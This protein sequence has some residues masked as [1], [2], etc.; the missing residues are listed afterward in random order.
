MTEPQLLR[1][2]TREEQALGGGSGGAGKEGE[3]LIP[4]AARPYVGAGEGEGQGAGSAEGSASE[5]GGGRTPRLPPP[6]LR[7]RRWVS[8]LPAARPPGSLVGVEALV[9]PVTGHPV[10]RDAGTEAVRSVVARALGGIGAT[11]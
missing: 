11:P 1:V 9:V 10:R 3:W 7:L 6:L 2:L 4:K 5:R 8:L